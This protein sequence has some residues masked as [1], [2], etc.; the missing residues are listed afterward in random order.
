MT[1]LKRDFPLNLKSCDC[2]RNKTFLFPIS[3]G[4]G[5]QFL[6][7]NVYFSIFPGMKS[8]LLN[9][10]KYLLRKCSVILQSVLMVLLQEY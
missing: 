8:K 7:K 1:C 10:A 3:V 9:M 5:V 6:P 2:H 4:G